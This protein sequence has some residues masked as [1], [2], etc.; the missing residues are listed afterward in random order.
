MMS[1]TFTHAHH[2]AISF[3]FGA[4]KW[5]LVV[6]QN[7]AGRNVAMHS[8][9]PSTSQAEGI[10]PLGTTT[11]N[12]TDNAATSRQV[13]MMIMTMLARHIDSTRASI[14]HLGHSLG[15]KW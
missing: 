12:A 8:S 6:L 15:S 2:R 1:H 4:L 5:L 9:T 7:G 13:M 11:G 10:T 14:M 3:A